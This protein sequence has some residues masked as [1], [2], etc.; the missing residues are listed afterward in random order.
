MDFNNKTK[1]QVPSVQIFTY[2]LI[3]GQIFGEKTKIPSLFWFWKN[4]NVNTADNFSLFRQRLDQVQMLEGVDFLNW[5][6]FKRTLNDIKKIR[7]FQVC[8]SIKSEFLVQFY[9]KICIFDIATASIKAN[10]GMWN[11][12]D[13]LRFYSSHFDH[14]GSFKL[15]FLFSFVLFFPF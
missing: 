3:L 15:M 1:V 4:W 2:S 14:S 8:F 13:R 12:N 5:F 7:S 9:L 11:Q 6:G 10:L